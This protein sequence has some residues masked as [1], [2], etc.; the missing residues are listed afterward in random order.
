[1]QIPVLVYYNINTLVL[2][3]VNS[4]RAVGEGKRAQ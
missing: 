3:I 1:M 4:E 2:A